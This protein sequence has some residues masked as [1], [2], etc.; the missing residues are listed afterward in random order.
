MSRY[1]RF[2]LKIEN[3][4]IHFKS[5]AIAWKWMLF[6]NLF[7]FLCLLGKMII[8]SFVLIS[9]VNEYFDIDVLSSEDFIKS[10][11]SLL[12]L[13]I[14]NRQVKVG[15]NAWCMLEIYSSQVF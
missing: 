7:D 9:F 4:K 14:T 15:S 12:V 5:L 3:G 11:K 2:I 10:L 1:A 8:L 6:V 13:E